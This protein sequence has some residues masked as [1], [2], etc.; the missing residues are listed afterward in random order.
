MKRTLILIVTLLVIHQSWSQGPPPGVKGRLGWRTKA[1]VLYVDDA[2]VEDGDGSYAVLRSQVNLSYDVV[3]L[4]YTHWDFQWK[5]LSK[6]PFGDGI[7]DPW[8]QFERVSVS[9]RKIMSSSNPSRFYILGGRLSS[10]YEDVPGD[11]VGATIYGGLVLG[12]P[13]A[14]QWTVGA[15][16]IYHPVHATLWPMLG[17]NWRNDSGWRVALGFPRTSVGMQKGPV[18]YSLG[19]LA[20]RAMVG[21][22][23]KSTV[24]P[25][26]YLEVSNIMVSGGITYTPSPPLK[27]SLK[28]ARSIINEVTFY[29]SDEH[30]LSD[31]DVDRAFGMQLELS[32]RF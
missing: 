32:Y 18:T 3:T 31:Y 2:E 20:D 8:K 22:S 16:Y 7:H 17:Y 5:D 10:L 14:S 19:F 24:A 30:E 26:G 12:S 15:V 27:L 21:L 11:S 4:G 28:L 23:D 29:D 13:R 9:A 25:D 6:L 1:S